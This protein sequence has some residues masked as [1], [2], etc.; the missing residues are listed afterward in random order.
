MA[1]RYNRVG[2]GPRVILLVLLVLFLLGGGAFWF[3]VL[4]LIDARSAM[5]PVLQPIGLGRSAPVATAEDEDLL[6]RVRFERRQE[7]LALQDQELD[8]RE[9]EIEEREEELEQR[10]QELE[11]RENTLAEREQSF[12]QREADYENRRANLRRNARTLLNMPPEQAVAI[13]EGYDNQDLVSILR[14]TDE[15]AEEEGEVSLVSVWLSELPADRAAEIQ[16]LMAQ[17]PG[18]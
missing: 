11:D 17:R 9:R 10:V 8:R 15:I 12:A 6:D 1:P 3:D 13:L 2:A 4:G 16:R 18:P 5:Q 7:Q 14:I